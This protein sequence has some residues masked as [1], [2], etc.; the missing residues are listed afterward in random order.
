MTALDKYDRLEATGL[1][2]ASPQDQRI[3][4]FV[5]IG[6][7]TLVI[8][9]S[10]DQA[11]AHWS[12]A[13]IARAPSE[14]SNQ[15]GNP[16]IFHPDGDPGETLEI[17]AD[18]PEIIAAIEKLRAAVERSRP[19]PGRLRIVTMFASF[20]AVAAVGVLWLPGA[21]VQHTVKVVPMV[22]RVEIGTDLLRRIQR[23]TGPPCGSTTD[24]G[25]ALKSLAKL[26]NRL[27]AP[28]GYN[29]LVVMRDGVRDTA[30]LPGGILLLNADFIE[31]YDAPDVVAGYIVAERLRMTLHNPLK[32]FLDYAGLVTSFRLLTTGKIGEDAMQSYSEHLLSTP[33]ITIDDATLLA[34]FKAW[35]VRSSA[36]AYAVDPSGETTLPL[37]EADP[38]ASDTPDLVLDDADWLRLQSICDG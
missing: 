9:D 14:H 25:G 12:L 32:E 7:T 10:K 17:S 38:Y 5:S 8:I 26:G 27:P 15:S 19:H 28:D 36:Y 1:W 2:R 20:A 18:Y 21:L 4:V 34:G 35:S 6:D 3:E 37:I 22:N 33:Q 31:G 11:L 30:H 13:A 16:V 29:R 23:L 24:A